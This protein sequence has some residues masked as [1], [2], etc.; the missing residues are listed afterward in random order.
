[1]TID[2]AVANKKDV[3]A[4]CSVNHYKALKTAIETR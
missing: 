2:E 4:N 3:L 1:M